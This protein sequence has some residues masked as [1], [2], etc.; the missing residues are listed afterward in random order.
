MKKV[1]ENKNIIVVDVINSDTALCYEAI[2]ETPRTSRSQDRK[3]GDKSPKDVSPRRSDRPSE[4]IGVIE[5][6]HLEAEPRVR[7]SS[8]SSCKDEDVQPA[9]MQAPK[10]D[11]QSLERYVI[12]ELERKFREKEKSMQAKSPEIVQAQI[13]REDVRPPSRRSSRDASEGR[14]F[15]R[16]SRELDGDSKRSSRELEE[17]SKRSS[18]EIS[19]D[20]SKRCSRDVCEDVV[21]RSSKETYNEPLKRSSREMSDDALKRSSREMDLVES[22]RSSREMEAES[23][24]SSKASEEGRTPV[25]EETNLKKEL[26]AGSKISSQPSRE[27]TEEKRSSE[28]EVDLQSASGE[29]KPVDEADEERKGLF[30]ATESVDDELPYVPTT[31]PQER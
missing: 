30:H 12:E 17:A 10:V 13:I 31:L 29:V 19:D 24:R 15:I 9:P 7:K 27:E 18:R 25:V 16:S 8:H 11:E 14:T 3:R 4:T 5:L 1:L 20:A 21:R 6:E 28:S 2:I 26:S 22:K 23:K